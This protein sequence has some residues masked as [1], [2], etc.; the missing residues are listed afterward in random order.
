VAAGNELNCGALYRSDDGSATWKPMFVTTTEQPWKVIVA[1]SHLYMLSQQLKFPLTLTGNLY[2]RDNGGSPASWTRISPQGENDVPIAAVT[3]LLVAPDGS[4]LARVSNGDGGALLRSVNR[5]ATWSAVVIP[6]LLSVGNVA[7]FGDAIVV[8]PTTYMPHTS[9]GFVSTDG[10]LT[11]HALSI[12]PD[13]PSDIGTQAMLGGNGIERALTLRLVPPGAVLPDQPVARYASVDGGR[14]W[15]RVL[16]G[17]RPAPGCAADALWAQTARARYVLYH[18]HLFRAPSGLP[19][20]QLALTLP[21]APDT[22]QQVLAV[23]GQHTDIIY[24]VSASGIWRFD[25]GRWQNSAAGLHLG[26]PA[27]QVS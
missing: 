14:S 25:G 26:G 21:V 12:L 24:V 7:L 4:L 27:P 1:S 9:P 2:R 15:Q 3:D 10:G 5:G 23:A 6:D 8:T 19:W 17:A 20:Q 13:A 18:G 16:C 22:V 11:W